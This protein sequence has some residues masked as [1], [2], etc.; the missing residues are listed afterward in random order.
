MLDRAG[1]LSWPIEYRCPCRSVIRVPSV[2]GMTKENDPL[3]LAGVAKSFGQVRAVT[4]ADMTVRS[5][6][7]VALLGPN[8]AGRST[9]IAMFA[10]PA[11]PGHGKS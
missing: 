2:D 1:H 9:T 10:E 4:G 5:G 8:G 6:E 7:T 3:R 11:P